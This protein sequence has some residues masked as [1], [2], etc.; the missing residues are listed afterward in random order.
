MMDM[1]AAS[2]CYLFHYIGTVYTAGKKTGYCPEEFVEAEYFNNVYE[3]TKYKG[4]KLALE[5]CSRVGIPL[6]IYRPSIVYGDSES[7]RTFQFKTL[8]Y[9]VRMVQFLRDIFLLDISE[10][11]GKNAEEM[12]VGIDDDGT[13]YCSVRLKKKEKGRINVIPINYFVDACMAIMDECL[14]GG[15]FQIVSKTPKRLTD[16]VEYSQRFFNIRGIRDVD[17]GDFDIVPPNALEALVNSRLEIYDP[18][19]RDTR[20]FGSE[21]TED[22]LGKRGITCPDLDYQVFDRC[23]QYAIEADWGNKIFEA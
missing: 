6:N 3:E 17:E 2:S 11:Q 16:L 14:D 23:M 7:G 18:Y 1:A 21:N 8:Y 4:E 13:T 15:I 5:G 19:I 22:I 12:G 10:N 9:V 20:I